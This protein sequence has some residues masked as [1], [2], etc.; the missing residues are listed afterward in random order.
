MFKSQVFFLFLISPLALLIPSALG[1]LSQS[2]FNDSLPYLWPMPSDFTFG[3]ATLSVDP[4]LSLATAGD[5]GN[6]EI[7]KAAFDRYRGIIF[8]HASGVSMFDKFWGRRRTFVYDISELKIVVQS[9]S[10]EV[11]WMGKFS[12]FNLVVFRADDYHFSF[13]SFN[14]MWMR[15]IHC[16]YRR[17]M[18]S[19]LLGKPQSR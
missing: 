1:F 17:R 2:G 15:A 14:L 6:S 10:E 5:G 18:L 12:F 9:D 3:N 11:S 7:L 13:S 8:K 19:R 16:L 4:H